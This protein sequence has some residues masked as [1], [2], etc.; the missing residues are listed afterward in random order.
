MVALKLFSLPK[1][2][3]AQSGTNGSLAR[4]CGKAPASSS[5]TWDHTRLENS[6]TNGSN[7]CSIVVGRVRIITSLWRTGDDR[8]L[9]PL[10]HRMDK[11]ELERLFEKWS[12]TPRPSILGAEDDEMGLLHT[13]L[14][15]RGTLS[16]RPFCFSLA[17]TPTLRPRSA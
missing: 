13:L 16:W 3:D 10:S 8:T 4:C 12:R 7:R 11:V 5:W 6:G 2:H 14:H 17:S 1:T 15:A 9:P